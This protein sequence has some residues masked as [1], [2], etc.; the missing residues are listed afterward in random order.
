M[1]TLA[2][3]HVS[4][5]YEGSVKPLLKDLT[6]HFSAGWSGV[7]GANGSGKTTLLRLALGELEP[8]EGS[9]QR[10]DHI[11]FCPQ[12]TDDQPEELAGFVN[13]SDP[14]ACVLR[15]RLGLHED[16]PE[17][18]TTLSHGERKRA[19]I[20]VSLWRQP[21]VLL[22]DEPTNHIDAEARALIADALSAFR[23]IGL[24]VSHDRELL[25]SLCAQCLFLD[26]PDAVMR[27]GNYSKASAD[28]QIDEQSQL[29]ERKRRVQ[30]LE[31][32]TKESQARH[33]EA[34]RA[35]RKKSKRG[36]PL[37]DTD[38]RA[39]IDMARVSG[40]DGQ[41]GRLANQMKGRIARAREEAN[42]LKFKKQY[43]A[44][45]WLES[46]LSPRKFLVAIP[47]ATIKLD[48][49]RKLVVPKLAM[50]RQ[51]R[52]AIT[53]AN[54]SGKSTLIGHILPQVNV[55]DERLVYV[56]QEIDLSR[57]REIMSQVHSLSRKQLGHVMT[58]VSGLG[59]RPERL[60]DN[61]DVSPGELRKVL[62]ALGVIRRPH[63]I[64]MDEPTNHLDLPAI[65]LLE[66]ALSGCTCGLL[67]V[68]HDMRFLSKL[69]DKRWHLQQEGRTVQVLHEIAI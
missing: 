10:P 22:V 55:D 49:E 5:T 40:K 44:N 39:K 2:F 36:L 65:E 51:D 43:A 68:S 42:D 61:Q 1:S 52:I 60:L 54:G 58:V 24:L 33:A 41:A 59:S 12:R 63:L 64:V 25:D 67:L 20:A 8:Q 4:F 37:H 27:P 13:S 18:W 6:A 3:H 15:G 62:L 14:N 46:D 48:E 35:D 53:G 66:T 16:W 47:E 19:Q 11:V 50:L 29:A 45:F 30:E 28:A 69:C 17:R 9:I 26:P 31:R 56:P 7:L 34:A 38:A 21:G 57:T 32:L 23:G